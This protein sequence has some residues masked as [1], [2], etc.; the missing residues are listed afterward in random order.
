MN[1]KETATEDFGAS[2]GSSWL[3]SRR[4]LFALPFAMLFSS[5]FKQQDSQPSQEAKRRYKEWLRMEYLRYMVRQESCGVVF[6]REVF[7][8]EFDRVTHCLS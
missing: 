5:V 2:R 7:W 1:S 8:R 3:L 4:T 6:D